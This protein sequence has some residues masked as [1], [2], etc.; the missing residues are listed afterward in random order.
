M[1]DT[2][3]DQWTKL[4]GLQDY[5]QVLNVKGQN[6]LPEDY[7]NIFTETPLVTAYS[8]AKETQYLISGHLKQEIH[9][10]GVTV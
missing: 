8:D 3:G 1:K 7:N 5:F 2:F 10:P 9:K 6:V 4:T